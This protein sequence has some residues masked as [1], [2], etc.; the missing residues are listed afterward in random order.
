MVRKGWMVFAGAMALGVVLGCS[1]NPYRPT[2][3]QRNK[4]RVNGPELGT[5][6]TDGSY[7]GG[8]PSGYP[9][10]PP[11]TVNPPPIGGSTA[12]PVQGFPP[13]VPQG[14]NTVPQGPQPRVVPETP[15]GRTG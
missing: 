1:S 11:G 6:M 13:Y 3:F 7:L 2:L 8:D 4:N 15:T 5:P 12:P 9:M 10:V 14:T